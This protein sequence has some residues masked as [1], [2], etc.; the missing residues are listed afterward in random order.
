MTDNSI[1]NKNVNRLIIFLCHIFLVYLED[2]S[3]IGVNDIFGNVPPEVTLL[4]EVYRS[5]VFISLQK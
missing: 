2:S 4:V 5:F 1:S 3:L